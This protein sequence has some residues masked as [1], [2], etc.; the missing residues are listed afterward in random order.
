[1]SDVSRRHF[2]ATGTFAAGA[3]WL[4][5][6]RHAAADEDACTAEFGG[7]RVGI[8]SNVLS[9]FSP[10][11]EAM[12]GHIADLGVHWIELAH[13]H[14]EVTQDA[15]RIAEVQAM[16]A[17]HNIRMEAYF[18]GEIEADA[19]GLRRTFEF[20]RENGASVLVGQPTAE[21]FPLLDALVKEFDIR[22][23]IHNYGP[24]HRF[25]R[26]TDLLI[27][28]APW[29][30]RIGY[31]LDTGHAMRSGENPVEAVRRMG[32]RL[33]GVHLREHEAIRRDP[34]P[35]ETIIGEGAL[36][37][38]AFCTALR[39]VGFSGPLSLEVYFN[40]QEPMESLRRGL[41]N[42]AKAARRPG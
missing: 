13:W 7:F 18:L 31:C 9:A 28:A 34:Q 25:D 33:Y 16:L 23:A 11:L 27:A 6:P 21:A 30:W 15:E 22:L 37:L 42:L 29:D 1:M 2:L 40:P 19:E 36:D 41:A 4:G 3:A 35:P 32:S 10:E 5:A 8:Q 38:A 17:H 14:Y 26:I 39:D 24:G 20:A 12:L